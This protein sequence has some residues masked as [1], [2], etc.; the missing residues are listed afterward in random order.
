MK[1][2][3]T[4]KKTLDVNKNLYDHDIEAAVLGAI[5]LENEQFKS[6]SEDFSPNV[7]EKYLHR[8]VAESILQ[9]FSKNEPIDILTVTKKIH[10]NGLLKDIGG[11]YE[12][13]VLTNRIASA[14]NLD[15]HYKILQEKYVEREI[16]KISEMAKQRV[17]SYGYDVFDTHDWFVKSAEDIL[18]PIKNKTS[19]SQIQQVHEEYLVDMTK[20]IQSGS[21]TGVKMHIRYMDNLTGGWKS[22]HMITIA[23][24]TSIGKSIFGIC[25]ALYPA[26]YDG[27]PTAFFSLEMTK[28]DVVNRVQSIISGINSSKLSKKQLNSDEVS[29]LNANLDLSKI[30]MYVDDKPS[31]TLI[32]FRT[33]ARKLVQENG[34]KLIVLDYIQLMKSGSNHAIR[35]QE[36]SEIARGIKEI[37][38]ELSVPIISLA[39]LNRGVESRGGDKKPAL[40]DLRESGEIEMSSDMVI[41][42][43]RPEYYGISEYEYDGAFFPNTDGLFVN[44]IA[45]HRG[46]VLGEV[47]MRLIHEQTKLE[48]WDFDITER[49]VTIKDGEDFVK[50]NFDNSKKSDTFVNDTKVEVLSNNLDFLSQGKAQE[51]EPF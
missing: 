18:N 3:V 17:F 31:M 11:A 50:K 40:H 10:E 26:M 38:K 36:V 4:K 1:S 22:G 46:G 51:E 33:K 6:I 43:Y 32:E 42:L 12:V 29:W 23:A 13:S 45:K 19:V 48:N 24:R 28:Q 15:A 21:P 25:S 41:L 9:L 30:P 20:I 16:V 47:Y 7:F 14:Q 37:A 5:L 35:E 8:V 44:I 2:N 34:V 27:T 39:Q 49:T